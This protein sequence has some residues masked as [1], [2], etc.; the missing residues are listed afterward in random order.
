MQVSS[1]PQR[2]PPHLHRPSDSSHVKPGR[3]CTPEQ[4]FPPLHSPWKQTFG[5]SQMGKSAPK[6]PQRQVP[7]DGSQIASP[8]H[9]TPSQRSA[10]SQVKAPNSSTT[11]ACPVMHTGPVTLPQ[12]QARSA[13]LQTLLPPQ[14]TPLQ[15]SLMQRP[16]SQRSSSP[17]I[18]PPHLH[19]PSTGSQVS[20]SGQRMPLQGSGT[21]Q[22]F[23]LQISP[24]W[25]EKMPHLQTPS[26]GS[27]VSPRTQVTPTQRSWTQV[28]VGSVW[29]ISFDLQMIRSSP[30]PHLQMP[31][32][33]SQVVA[34]SRHWT[35]AHRSFSLVSSP[36]H[37]VPKAA[38]RAMTAAKA[39]Q[40]CL[41]FIERS[42]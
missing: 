34:G 15:G 10:P 13:G 14:W 3:H 33:G 30:V 37:A 36:P 26:V 5:D 6:P 27:Q 38:P 1:S 24:S 17:Q 41:E 42:S 35:E 8:S 7:S 19:A 12:W 21:T 32:V 16:S 22:R 40:W 39:S 18:S 29:Q 31:S 25:H 2:R 23:W 28:G 4:G 11:Q 20:P 9:V